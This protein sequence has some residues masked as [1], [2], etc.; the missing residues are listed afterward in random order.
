MFKTNAISWFEIPVNDIGRAQAFYEAIL[1]F[2]LVPMDMEGMSM[3]MFPTD[4]MEGVGGALVHMPE[5]CQPSAQG[6]MAYLNANPDLQAILDRVEAAGG[7]I[8]MPKTQITPEYGY[9]AV[10]IDTEG[11]RVGLHS[12]A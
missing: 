12:G 1:G 2:P 5:V 9:M 4:V 11:N 10:F 6:T 3:R 7:T 8:A